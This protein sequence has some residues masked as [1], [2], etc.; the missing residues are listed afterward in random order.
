MRFDWRV[1]AED[2]WSLLVPKFSEYR[3]SV[4]GKP[5]PKISSVPWSYDLD[6]IPMLLIPLWWFWT[7]L[8][9]TFFLVISA[10]FSPFSPERMTHPPS[11]TPTMADRSLRSLEFQ[12]V[13]QTLP[14]STNTLM[15]TSTMRGGVIAVTII[16]KAPE[17]KCPSSYTIRIIS[18]CIKGFVFRSV[19]QPQRKTYERFSLQVLLLRLTKLSNNTLCCK[20]QCQRRI[21]FIAE[22]MDCWPETRYLARIASINLSSILHHKIWCNHQLLHPNSKVVKFTLFSDDVLNIGTTLTNYSLLLVVVFYMLTH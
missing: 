9:Q 3:Y 16:T 4:L 22:L 12:L 14:N 8:V 11:T 20:E 7:P 15:N 2:V 17:H 13:V 6:R 10:L 1:A 21:S 5:K 18:S 19:L